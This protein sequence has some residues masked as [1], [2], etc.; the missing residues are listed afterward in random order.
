MSTRAFGKNFLVFIN[1]PFSLSHTPSPEDCVGLNFKCRVK[2][3]F[4]VFPVQALDGNNWS[5]S[6]FRPLYPRI[7]C[8]RYTNMMLG[9]IRSR[10]VI[11]EMS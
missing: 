11:L 3:K 4:K 6:E 7:E 1:I 8:L 5:V 9:G 2:V 10:R